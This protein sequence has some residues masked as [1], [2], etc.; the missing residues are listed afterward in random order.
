MVDRISTTGLAGIG[1]NGARAV[2]VPLRN[3]KPKHNVTPRHGDEPSSDQHFE[4]DAVAM[5]AYRSAGQDRN[6]V[7]I[8]QVT[9]MLLADDLGAMIERAGRNLVLLT[10][11]LLG[12]REQSAAA[13]VE[14]FTDACL[15][16]VRLAIVRYTQH[17]GGG[18][19]VPVGLAFN[20]VVVHANHASG[21]LTVEMG[22]ADFVDRIDFRAGGVVFDV[23][24]SEAVHQSRPGIFVDIGSH[25]AGT[26]NVLIETARRDL[27][28]FGAELD[29]DGVIVLIRADNS[30]YSGHQR[31]EESLGVDLVIPFRDPN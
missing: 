23:R 18:S 15:D 8:D 19:R 20:A 1:S 14:T 5:G 25:G 6:G 12:A 9:S 7:A 28:N 21:Q 13:M 4:E 26:A 2:L 22:G 27:P 30:D 16:E 24:G 10:T 17:S 11:R 29:T 31:S 3:Q